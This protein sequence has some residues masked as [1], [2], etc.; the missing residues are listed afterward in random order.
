MFLWCHS[1]AG[2][3]ELIADCCTMPVCWTCSW[4]LLGGHLL[5]AKDSKPIYALDV[6]LLRVVP[7]EIQK[8][9]KTSVCVCLCLC[10][11]LINFSCLTR[12]PAK[13]RFG[14][15]YGKNGRLGS[16][17]GET[18]SRNQLFDPGFLFTTSDT[19]LVGRT[20]LPQ[21]KTS[22]TDRQTDDTSFQKHDR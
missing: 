18:G 2:F 17:I 8:S 21:Y 6:L 12:S 22:Q 9:R 13:A 1:C 14:R 19:F 15:L 20:V 5:D 16:H 11:L 4:L 10:L 7:D 3:T